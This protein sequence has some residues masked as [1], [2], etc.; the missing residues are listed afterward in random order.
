LNQHG[1]DKLTVIGEG[2]DRIDDQRLFVRDPGSGIDPH[3]D[4]CGGDR[5]NAFLAPAWCPTIGD[6][7]DIDEAVM[8]ADQRRGDPG[9]RGE[10]KGVDED[11]EPGG[12]DGA[13]REPGAILFRRKAGHDARTERGGMRGSRALRGTATWPNNAS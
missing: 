13:D 12:I 6:G 4:A 8:G 7:A 3:R 9:T 2:R 11:L 10:H 5:A 1:R